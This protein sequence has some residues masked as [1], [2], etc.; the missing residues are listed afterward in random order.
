MSKAI[1]YEGHAKATRY[2][3]QTGSHSRQAWSSM[4][5]SFTSLDEAKKAASHYEAK[6]YDTRISVAGKEVSR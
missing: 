6:G 3:L 1:V 2:Q 5:G 4:G